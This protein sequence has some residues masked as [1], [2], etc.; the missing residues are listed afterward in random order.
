MQ[1]G[2]LVV[3]ISR[4]HLVDFDALVQAAADGKIRVAIDVFP[5]EP[6]APTTRFANDAK[7]HPVATP[8]RG[9]PGGRH[10][11]GDMI[12][13]DIDNILAGRRAFAAGRQ[14]RK[15]QR[16]LGA[17]PCAAHRLK[18]RRRIGDDMAGLE[19]NNLSKAYD[20]TQVLHDINLTIEDGEFVVFV[21]PSGC[22]KSTLL[23]MIA[24]LEEITGGEL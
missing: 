14:S 2:T 13:H 4:S 9:R 19:L 11:M 8:R 1:A 16:I 24:G 17:P 5:S 15:H 12:V 6:V 7:R 22:G 23:R 10:P 18:D 20:A 3:V 21:G